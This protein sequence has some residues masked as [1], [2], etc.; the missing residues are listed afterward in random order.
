MVIFYHL[1]MFSEFVIEPETKFTM[2]Y[3]LLMFL[4]VLITLNIGISLKK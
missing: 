2:G 4:G 3:S 1:V